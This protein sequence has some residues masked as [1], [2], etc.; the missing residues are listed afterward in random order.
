MTTSTHLGRCAA[1]VLAAVALSPVDAY[2]QAPTIDDAIAAI[3]AYGPRAL[4]EQG[5]PGM[6]IAITDRTHTVKILTFGYADVASKKPVDEGTRFP[7]GSISK[8]M[9]ALA[10]LQLHDKG[11]VD[12][13]APVRRYLPWWSIQGGDG[14]VV[15]QLLSHT[16]GVT[17]DYSYAE[18][19][20]T[21]ADLR[22]AHTVFAPGT[23]WAYSNDGLATVGAISAA[24]SGQPWYRGIED[25]VFG[26]LRMTNSSAYFSLA[27]MAN[28]A[29]GYIY[30]DSEIVATPPHPALIAAQP[31]SFVNPAGSVISTPADM[32][33][34]MRFYLND[35]TTADGTRLLAPTT[36]AAMTT[37]DH[38][39]NGNPAG[40]KHPEL[41]EWPEF[42]TQ[43]GYGLAIFNTNGDHLIGHTGGIGGYTACMQ[44][45][46]TRGFGVIAMSNLIEAPLHPCAIVRYAMQVLRAQALGQPLPPAPD[47]PPIPPPVVVA[48]DYDGS[49][50]AGDGRSVSVTG[51]GG[52]MHLVDGGAIY[53]LVANGGDLFWTDDPRYPIYYVAFTRNKDKIVDGFTHGSAS[54]ARDGH[55]SP[56]AP[57]VPA[58]W[59]MLT[60]RYQTMV[61]GT[62]FLARI[63]IVRGVLTVDGVQALA[64]GKDGSFALGSST[65]R[66]DAFVDGKAQ[67]LR[68]DGVDLYRIEL[69]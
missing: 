2:A 56:A 68:L 54:Y 37:P 36:F 67:R 33:A 15:H 46:L 51:E 4:A 39:T 11:L 5:A 61:W 27:N 64:P 69:P 47:A 29:T 66:F 48:A 34:Y 21:L 49:Y 40:A 10:L 55:A 7:I 28:V 13:N 31:F 12:L 50:R 43:Y 1:A 65:L 16:A 6:S 17:D 19:G 14:I 58:S 63:V 26:P 8:S 35:G 41:A 60:G 53:Q 52:T 25:T 57:A 30:R 42:Y 20:Y 44:V 23:A 59:Q 45:N 9:T 18:Y 32:A 38:L 62:P 24:I 22:N 3:S